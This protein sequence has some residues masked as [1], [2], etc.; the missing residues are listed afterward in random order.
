MAG[1]VPQEL[2][3]QCT[4]TVNNVVK[5]RMVHAFMKSQAKRVG[6]T[7]VAT[8][9]G[10]SK[11]ERWIPTTSAGA[12]LLPMNDHGSITKNCAKKNNTK[13]VGALPEISHSTGTVACSEHY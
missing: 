5:Y 7:L 6:L 10:H 11:W 13:K 1:R 12:H 9:D 3:Q 8:T 4:A 2:E